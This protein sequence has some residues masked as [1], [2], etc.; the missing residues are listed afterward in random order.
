MSV[1]LLPLLRSLR[2]SHWVKNSFL[3]A[4]A[5]FGLKLFQRESW[6]VLAAAFSAF[7]LAA[8][9]T[10]LVNDLADRPRDREN[11]RTRGR[12][13]ASGHLSTST[14]LGAALLL[15]L[16]ALALAWLGRCLVPL[17]AYVAASH[18]Y[19]FFLKKLPLADVATLTLLYLLRLL[20]GAQAVA[21]PPSPWLLFCGG[22][23]ALLLSL[24]KRLEKPHGLYSP[25]LLRR[26][27]SWLA[28]ATACAYLTYAFRPGTWAHF[29]PLFPLTAV[30]VLAGL[31]RYRSL[32][33]AGQ[34]DPAA[35]LFSDLG[36]QLA[37]LAW[38]ASVVLL[39]SLAG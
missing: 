30:P 22:L 27:V 20:A 28:V 34:A 39:A 16:A 1:P 32:A 33:L 13:I 5:V 7:C 25:P 3:L 17:V 8:S 35:A 10:Y 4:P 37:T 18:A 36:M 21:V 31:W 38:G 2:P 11:P 15:T 14:A 19:T 6:P 9:A 24:G 12:P 23:L 26:A 29:S